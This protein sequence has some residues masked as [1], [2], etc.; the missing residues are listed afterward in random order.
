MLLEQ[1]TPQRVLSALGVAY[2][3]FRLP[4]HPPPRFSP[5]C[6]AASGLPANLTTAG[7]HNVQDQVTSNKNWLVLNRPRVAGFDSTADRRL[8]CDTMLV[9]AASLPRFCAVIPSKTNR[10]TGKECKPAPGEGIKRLHRNLPVSHLGVNQDA[11]SRISMFCPH[12]LKGIPCLLR[13]YSR[14][15][16]YILTPPLRRASR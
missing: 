1:R 2:S 4:S 11:P 6:P 13:A 12:R 5:P 10:D 16:S 7:L 8:T 3:Q 14:T 15:L 9:G